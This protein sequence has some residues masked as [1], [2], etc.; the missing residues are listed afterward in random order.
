[1]PRLVR[2]SAQA[3]ASSGRYL[4]VS[5]VSAY[6]E[7][8]TVFDEA[9]GPLGELAEPESEEVS[10]YYG[11]LKAACERMVV[12]V[13]GERSLVVRPGL[14]VGPHDPTNRFTY[15]VTR[16]AA[17]GKVLAPAPPDRP[18]QF[19]DARDLAEWMLL[20]LER[21][22]S[23]TFNASGMPIGLGG[24]LD[25][26]QRVSGSGAELV[27]VAEEALV[28][29]GVAPWSEL[30]LW[31]PASEDPYGRFSA[32]PIAKALA[33]GLTFRPLD[34]TVADTLAWARDAPAP[35]GSRVVKPGGL[36]REREQALLAEAAA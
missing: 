26:C 22:G 3:L 34:T 27:W 9:S 7:S 8:A 23:G 2:D 32:L 14:V 19:I 30:P 29:A 28:E 4:F 36:A 12:E 15:W 20:L 33:H 21:G 1:V 10:R 5:S 11:E 31:L 17:G 13:F 35:R 25:V 18:V 16:V 6:A 24:V